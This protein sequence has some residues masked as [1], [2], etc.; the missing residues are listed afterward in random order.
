MTDHSVWNLRVGQGD[1]PEALRRPLAD[2]MEA[3]DRWEYVGSDT[4]MD[5]WLSSSP[6]LHRAAQA[7]REAVRELPEPTAIR[8]GGDEIQAFV[9]QAL[10]RV[11][12]WPRVN[13]VTVRLEGYYDHGGTPPQTA[14]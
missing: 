6:G 7:M 4:V 13:E 8:L 1:L 10:G 3:I 12:E 9:D 14:P 2:L 5:R 11:N